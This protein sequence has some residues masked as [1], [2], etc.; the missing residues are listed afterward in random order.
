MN[1]DVAALLALQEEDQV[2]HGLERRLAL[3]EPRLRELDRQRKA[4]EDSLAQA[5]TQVE[6][7]SA[8]MRDLETR[9]AEHRQ[10]R[11]RNASQLDAVRSA[12]TA[13]AAMSQMDQA[14]RL[15]ADDEGAAR[16]QSQRV[17]DLQRV[18]QVH[19]RALADIVE[20]QSEARAAV[21]EER[22]TLEEELRHARM[23][24]DGSAAR[25]PRALLGTYDRIWRK[26]APNVLVALRGGSCGA[27]DLNLPL[28]RRNEMMRTGEIVMC[29]GCGVLL[30]ATE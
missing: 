6:G 26:K 18:V 21:A 16:Q 9:A 27:C 15:V 23:K 13:S 7:E 17:A 25:V 28:Q 4:A 10:L 12:R 1:A 5:R 24:R 20:S 22:R 19:E 30:Y 3:L 2:I 29:E 11:D 14:R 8:R